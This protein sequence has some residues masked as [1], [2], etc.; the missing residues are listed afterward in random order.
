[1]SR[2]SRYLRQKCVIAR[3]LLDDDGNVKLDRYGEA[4]YGEGETFK[5]RREQKVEQV[6]TTDG[7]NLVSSKVYYL[8]ETAKLSK[9][10]RIDG[11]DIL[12]F[13]EYT[14]GAGNLVGY[15]AYV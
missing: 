14:D 10:D 6:Q 1:M 12:E 9:T 15:E 7:V 11:M 4:L 2:M 8:D 3:A 13:S 5:C